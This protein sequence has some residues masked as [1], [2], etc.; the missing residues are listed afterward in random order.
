MEKQ[1]GF[2]IVTRSFVIW[3]DVPTKHSKERKR[4]IIVAAEVG[5]NVILGYSD[6]PTTCLEA[7]GF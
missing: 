3:A 6:I 4:R 2:P 1:D 5:V 7:N